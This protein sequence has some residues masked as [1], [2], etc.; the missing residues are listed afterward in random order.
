QSAEGPGRHCSSNT[1]SSQFLG[2]SS[3]KVRKVDVSACVTERMPQ[4][5]L[6]GKVREGNVS[7]EMD[8]CAERSWRIGRVLSRRFV[9]PASCARQKTQ[10]CGPE[11]E[12][13]LKAHGKW[14][15]RSD[16]APR[17]G[18]RGAW[19]FVVSSC[20]AASLGRRGPRR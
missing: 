12:V 15:P 9:G 4:D 2:L 3:M 7:R 13:C 20:L 11:D 6:R 8:S 1:C 17:V 14:L 5:G 10:R 16:Q 19:S 18:V